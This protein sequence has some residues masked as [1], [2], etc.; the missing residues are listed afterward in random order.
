MVVAAVARLLA[1]PPSGKLSGS[2]WQQPTYPS[3]APRSCSRPPL[4]RVWMGHVCGSLLADGRPLQHRG[5]EVIELFEVSSYSSVVR[6]PRRCTRAA[7]QGT[8]RD[9]VFHNVECLS[10]SSPPP[11]SCLFSAC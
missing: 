3:H 1:R 5:L 9:P 4:G 2:G 8:L 7:R 6:R 10:S 11:C